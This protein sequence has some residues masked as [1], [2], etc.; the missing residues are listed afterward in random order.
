MP[1]W[2][3]G[4]LFVCTWKEKTYLR[5]IPLSVITLTLSF[6]L[7][8]GC[9]TTNPEFQNTIDSRVGTSINKLMDDVGEPLYSPEGYLGGEYIWVV[10]H[11]DKT[12][13]QFRVRKCRIIFDVSNEGIIQKAESEGIICGMQGM[14]DFDINGDPFPPEK[15]GKIIIIE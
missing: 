12:R 8:T 2:E 9:T 3:G 15:R 13:R 14:P 1:E 11:P 5:T 10:F 7:T 4:G 6:L